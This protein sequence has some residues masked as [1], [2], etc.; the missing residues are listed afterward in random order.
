MDVISV[1]EWQ[2]TSFFEVLPS[3]PDPDSPW[4]YTEVVYEVTR[5][6]LSMT[7]AI[8]P[9]YRDV[10]LIVRHGEAVSYELNATQV[11]DLSYTKDASGESLRIATSDS[12][13]I[14][15]RLNPGISIKHTVDHQFD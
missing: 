4:P 15:L 10:R 3:Y 2:L 6:D 11:Q 5:G 14:D 9:A 1:E 7:C 13:Y 12:E 8:C